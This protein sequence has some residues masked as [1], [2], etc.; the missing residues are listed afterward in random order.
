LRLVQ[1][2]RG[3]AYV[4]ENDNRLVVVD[5][6][7][8][9]KLPLLP[10]AQAAAIGAAITA[11]A[12]PSGA[13]FAYD[14][15]VVH[16]HFDPLRPFYRLDLNDG[17][18]TQF[19]LSARTGELVQ[20]TSGRE[21]AWNWVG[22]V[23]HWVYFT[24]LRSSFSLWDRTVW[25]VS[26]IAMLVAIAGTVLGV[27]RTL[28]AQR[29]RRPSLS[30]YRLKWMRWHHILGLFASL[31]VLTWMLSGWLSMDH[32]RLFSRGQATSAEVAA[33][34]GRS[35]PAGL[36]PIDAST[37]HALMPAKEVGFDVIAGVA[38]LTTV[39]QNGSTSL[40]GE[41]GKALPPNLLMEL[42]Q[43]GVTQAWP[44]GPVTGVDRVPPTDVYALAEGWP[45]SAV[46]V[47]LSG[48]DAP[49]I[50]V[51]ASN[52]HL[53]TVMSGSRAAY[54]WVYYAL[55]TFN[56]PGLTTR[57]ILREVLVMVPLIFGLIFSIT[58]VVIGY[59]RLR[60]SIRHQRKGPA[61]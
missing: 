48:T 45:A 22:A 50:Y 40:Y 31:F 54:A 11:G 18:G 23:L 43:R 24:P 2:G 61:L 13:P 10:S 59:Q 4:V 58:G 42:V 17:A 15:W 49:A 41:D 44:T 30:F 8:G 27:I 34:H 53:L 60:K 9:A 36:A 35:L 3:P 1:R 7:T 46:R 38:I 6:R 57:P 14:Q 39:H 12:T 20:R 26:F 56:F 29:Q 55:H 5:A 21:R 25:I 16:N 32:G 47:G 37:L 33:Y 52:G 28:A 19:Y 51:D